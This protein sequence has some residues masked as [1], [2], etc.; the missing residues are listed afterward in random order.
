MVIVFLTSYW[1]INARRLK[2]EKESRSL[3]ARQ[4]RVVR[5]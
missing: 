4:T 1:L 2:Q 3:P 5:R